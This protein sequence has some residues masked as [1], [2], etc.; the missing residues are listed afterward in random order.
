M[1][2]PTI[3]DIKYA[4]EHSGREC[5]FFDRKTMQVFGQTVRDFKVVKSPTERFF[6]YAPIRI[7][8]CQVDYTFLKVHF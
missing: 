2:T 7:D 3:H 4:V 8:G 1:K 6:V 5:H